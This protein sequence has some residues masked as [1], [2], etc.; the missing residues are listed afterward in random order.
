M[1]NEGNNGRARWTYTEN[2]NDWWNWQSGKCHNVPARYLVSEPAPQN[3]LLAGPTGDSIFKS[4]TNKFYFC[5]LI[6][7]SPRGILPQTRFDLHRWGTM[8][9]HQTALKNENFHQSATRDV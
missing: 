5:A 8:S 9:P 3:R 4:E 2:A 7:Q 1:L 6:F